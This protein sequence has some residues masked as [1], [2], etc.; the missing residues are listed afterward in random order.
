MP[1]AVIMAG[2]RGERFWP[3]SRIKM[4][5]QF[6]SLVGGKTM[7]QLAVDRIEGLVGPADTYIVAGAEFREIILNQVPEL[8]ED[9]IIIEPSGRD[10]AAA[11]G[12][13]A[14]VLGR[15]NPREVVAVLPADHYVRDVSRFREVLAGAAA[16]A[17]G[18][19]EIV[20][21]GIAPERP[22]TGYGYICRGEECGVFAG[23]SAHRAVRFVEKP[24][25]ERALEYLAGGNYLWNSGIFVFRADLVD[26][27][28]KKHA[29]LLAEGLRKIGES[30]GTARYRETLEE[31][32]SG[33]PRISFDY[34]V[35]ERADNVL[36]IPCDFGWDDLGSWTALER[37]A[38]RDEKGNVLEGE[39]VL[40]DAADTYVYSPGKKVAVVGVERLIIV[41]A[42]DCLL[43]CRK[44]RA[45]DL[46]QVVQALREKGYDDVL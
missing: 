46:K 36:V 17:E 24:D 15:K 4:P 14:T 43:V 27:L 45:G 7:L 1:S 29:P 22:E 9:N 28:I 19:E 16:A 35:M 3:R 30:L 39:G 12:L 34:A 41:D 38:A 18:G 37:Y 8:P 2:G 13:A 20:T 40:L 11:V 26:R 23:V 42:G 44:D 10:T 21:L 33:L 6:L 5:K 32:Y 31:V 25:Y